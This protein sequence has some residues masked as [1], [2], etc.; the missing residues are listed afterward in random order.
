MPIVIT[1]GHSLE[2]VWPIDEMK[3]AVEY[4]A[5]ATASVSAHGGSND[6]LDDGQHADHRKRSTPVTAVFGNESGCDRPDGGEKIAERLGHT[7]QLSRLLVAAAAQADERER[8]NQRCA[9]TEAGD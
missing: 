3:S 1:F 9:R 2:E 7:R 5:A 4:L 6:D 8:H